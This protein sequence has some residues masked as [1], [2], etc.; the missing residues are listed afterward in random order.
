MKAERKTNQC[1]FVKFLAG[2]AGL[3]LWL[4]FQ[5]SAM[6]MVLNV[7]DPAGS[8]VP[9]FRW[10]IEVDTTHYVT[11]GVPVPDS[12]SV[13]IHRSYNPIALTNAGV[14]A[15]GDAGGS[16]IELNFSS[17]QRHLVSVLPHEGFGLGSTS[18]A[19]GQDIVT[20]TVNPLPTRAA[21]ISVLVFKDDNPINNIPD[22]PQEQ[23]L[24]GF[25]IKVS[26]VFGQVA[27]DVFGNPLGTT[28][29]VD[30]AGNVNLNPDGSPTVEVMGSGIITTDAAGDAL[31][32]NLAPGKYGVEA[33]P[34]A[35][36]GWQQTNT[37]EGT[38]VIDAWVRAGEPAVFGEFGPP[39]RHVF[40]GFVKE[41]NALPGSAN[42]G[43]ISGRIVNAHNSRPPDFTFNPGHPLPACW[44]GLNEKASRNG[45]Y[46]SP[47][48]EDSTFS[49]AGVPP[50]DYD[51]AIWDENLN[52][53][54]TLY[55]V[56]VPA[57]GGP[58]PLGDV[59]VF[60]WF[61][62]LE[63][64]VFH[65][66]NQNGF[67]DPGEVGIAEQAVNLRFRDGS[68]YQSFPTDLE[69]FVP[70]EE[71]FPFT[72]FLV[73]EVDFARFKATGATIIADNGGPVL[74]DM[75]WG[76]PS[77]DKLTPQEQCDSIDAVTGDCINPII[78]PN[79]GNNLSRTVTGPVL[80][81]ALTTF[82]Q[83][84][85]VIEW[86]KAAYGPG[87]NGG[88][89]GIIYYATTRAEDDPR[90]AAAEPWEPGI[91]R[92]QVSLYADNNL[93]NI[94]DDLNGNGPQLA[95]V[96]NH[97]FGWADGGTRGPED[98]DRNG[99]GSFDPGDAVQIVYSD[100]WDDNMP[101]GCNSPPFSVNGSPAQEC[102][103]G[104]RTYNQVRDGVFD[105]GYA[106]NTYH[107]GGIVSGGPEAPLAPGRYIVEAA[108]PPGYEHLKEEDK[109]VDFGEEYLPS[110]LLLPP[111]CVGDSRTVPAELSLFPGTAAPFAG[112][113]RRLCD[114]KS[115]SL[116]NGRNAA[117]DFFMFTPVPKAARMI[118]FLLNDLAN[119]FDPNH[120]NFGEKTGPPW[121]PVSVQDHT[122]REIVRVYSDEWGIYNALVPS[123]Y[124]ANLPTP[125]GVSP[126][127]LRVCLND[128]G[129]IP[130]PQDI[131]M[132]IVD[133]FF[134]PKFSQLCYSFDYWPGKT[135]Y[136][137]TP[138]M[139]VAASASR[140]DFPLDC[141]QPD[142]TPAIYSVSGPGGGPYVSAPGQSITITAPGFIAPVQVR[143]PGFEAG[144]PEPLLIARDYGFGVTP[145][146]VTIGGVQLTNLNWGDLQITATVP[147]GTVTGDLVVTRA[148]SG[149]S[150]VA[151]VTVTV[152]GPAPIQV[153]VGG[154]IQAAIDP[155]PKG[156]L[157]LVP[158]GIYDELV[159]MWKD[160]KLQGWGPHGTIIDATK[161]TADKL[162]TWHN[163]IAGLIGTPGIDLIPGQTA[164]SNL[165]EGPGI[166]VLGK[167]G[168]FGPARIDGLT[169]TG[170]SDGG[171]ILVNGYAPGLQISNTRILA[172]QGT[173]GGGI[174]FGHPYL[175]DGQGGFIYADAFNDGAD[176]HRNEIA[177]N[178]SV[179]AAGGG[180]ALFTGTDAYRV[181][182]N[183]ICGNFSAKDGGGIGHQGLSDG[184]LIAR[185]D[186]IFNQA[187]QQTAGAGGA[188]GGIM[189]AGGVP[190][191][192]GS[193]SPGTGSVKIISNLIQ[194]N[195]A[196]ADDGG[197]IML[198]RVNGQEVVASPQALWYSVDVFNN[199]IA[200]NVSGLA[201]AVALLDTLKANIINNTI[202][203]NDSTA[204]SAAAFTGGPSV[205]TPKPAGVVSRAHTPDLA[206][207]L[208]A[209]LPFSNPVLVNNIIWHNRSFHWEVALY[210]G[211]GGLLP[212]IA[213]GDPPVYD[214]LAVLGTTGALNPL[215]C[216]LTNTAG[217]DASNRAGDPLFTAGYVNGGPSQL[218]RPGAT[219]IQTIPAFDEGGNFIDLSFGPYTLFDPATGSLF[220]DYHIG[221][222]SAARE[223]GNSAIVSL[224]ADLARDFDNDSRPSGAGP[225]IGADEIPTV[226]PAAVDLCEGDLDRDGDVDYADLRIF[227]S[228]YRRTDCG[229]EPVCTGDFDGDLDVD[230]VDLR[231]FAEDYGRTDCP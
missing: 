112:T 48:N 187:F 198:R 209:G 188:G 70:F 167:N 170:A 97:P 123:T 77:R 98:L 46:A 54:I 5:P 214:D 218:L 6:A 204:T 154:S 152:G 196:G 177:L 8:P 84:T 124:T 176:L 130:N 42:P 173:F 2:L 51:L 217:Y 163:K 230:L 35:G 115:I 156:S 221:A 174:R 40:F 72:K 17:N 68:L 208:G 194:G 182:D 145:G 127:I 95:D 141:E 19:P 56:T 223:N 13:S 50:G 110:L 102:F 164:L 58:V 157:I 129:P 199:I 104:L 160:V 215:S 148:D 4:S 181:T 26:D 225:D 73:A 75:G 162:L 111:V 43:S 146:T 81:Q 137:D 201:G 168:T 96:D 149:R 114:R 29:Q 83:V 25:T 38:K 65:D 21:Q 107:P 116:N 128:P 125:S 63:S 226:G 49:I 18:I 147:A 119:V 109:N 161:T 165:E 138:I 222:G 103:E 31:V 12:I 90:Y 36:Q 212:D 113:M 15:S 117:V 229:L 139:P 94:I 37:I 16:S 220:G 227:R 120:P 213:A 74:P 224:Y 88:I 64:T 53:I 79:T 32:K 62:T 197:G 207:A 133:P 144:G 178:G 80:T 136:L 10:Q 180:V 11:P 193:L 101:T 78:N 9:G 231:I 76:Y 108:L 61:G 135:S 67:R 20:V 134:D 85:N 122:G 30:A 59:P 69:G 132:L 169:V 175:S 159:V 185:N 186:I 140:T 86:G 87:E 14:A 195:Q 41:F 126:N 23:G 45:V 55:G 44:I 33:I 211:Q 189:V 202:V 27:Q 219:N 205:S 216:L 52:Q 190:F 151:G 39:N 60:R 57:T 34:P 192:Q 91:P 93:D 183:F 142:R 158:P 105:G 153:P 22:L 92:V 210:G 7:V 82:T 131:E 100:S 228:D 66:A 121:L 200:N 150:N 206:A 179:G 172:N 1:G 203:N 155:A 166:I 47:C 99:N 3:L 89:S 184:G 171:G 24:A 28:Y 106:F 191:N 118:G 143:N 71:L